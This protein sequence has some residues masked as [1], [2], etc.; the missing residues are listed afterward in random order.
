MD[1][2]ITPTVRSQ[3]V[4]TVST[5]TDGM[6]IGAVRTDPDQTNMYKADGGIWLIL[7]WMGSIP[8]ICSK[9]AKGRGR[10]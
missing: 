2:V 6:S 9:D 10:W 3:V 7:L 4:F 1:A 5:A 8:R